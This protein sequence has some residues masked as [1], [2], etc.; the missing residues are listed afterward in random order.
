MQSNCYYIALTVYVLSNRTKLSKTTN[1]AH[2]RHIHEAGSC[3]GNQA[4][5][6][7]GAVHQLGENVTCCLCRFC[8]AVNLI[9]INVREYTLYIHNNPNQ[10]CMN[11]LRHNV[12]NSR[13]PWQLTRHD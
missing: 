11:N 4:Q 1:T 9:N 2:L 3:C 13:M 5:G 7:N 8:A 12:L 10:R 6:L